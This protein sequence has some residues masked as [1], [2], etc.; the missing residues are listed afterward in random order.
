MDKNESDESNDLLLRTSA[1][2]EQINRQVEYL[3]SILL[4]LKNDEDKED[5][6]KIGDLEG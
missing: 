4:E 2:K 1:L 6:T 5:D 3:K